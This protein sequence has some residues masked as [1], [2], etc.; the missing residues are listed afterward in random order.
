MNRAK[1]EE[2]LKDQLYRKNVESDKVECLVKDT[3]SDKRLSEG[4]DVDSIHQY[5]MSKLCIRQSTAIEVT[6]H[7]LSSVAPVEEEWFTQN[8]EPKSYNK[9]TL[10]NIYYLDN[11]GDVREGEFQQGS[12]QFLD[13]FGEEV[14]VQLWAYRKHPPL[15]QPPTDKESE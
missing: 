15:P 1:L 4:V 14:S 3:L 5:L 12:G 8:I 13:D 10:I 9:F 7:I 11:F 2:V 6:E